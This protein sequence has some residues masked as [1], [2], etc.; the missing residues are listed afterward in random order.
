MTC[1]AALHNLKRELHEHASEYPSVQRRQLLRRAGA[2]MRLAREAVPRPKP[3]K[4]EQF[5]FFALLDAPTPE[6]A[7]ALCRSDTLGR[8]APT[9]DSDRE[10]FMAL[11]S[12]PKGSAERALYALV[13]KRGMSAAADWL[14]V[15]ARAILSWIRAGA[16]P[17]EAASDV[18]ASAGSETSDHSARHTIDRAAL[19]SVESL[20]TRQ[21]AIVLGVNCMTISRARRKVRRG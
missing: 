14:D 20:S 18:L 1:A 6:P 3:A 21:A 4:P 17:A 8:P 2:L 16:V 15:D 11:A 7:P 12:R 13:S 19:A 10:A 9:P 5:A